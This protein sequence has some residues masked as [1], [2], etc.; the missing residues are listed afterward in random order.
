MSGNR[1]D[2][3]GPTIASSSLAAGRLP[4][5]DHPPRL[6]SSDL[7]R[8]LP[9]HRRSQERQISN[10][11]LLGALTTYGHQS[12]TSNSLAAPRNHRGPKRM[13]PL[14]TL[15]SLPLLAYPGV[16]APVF[17]LQHLNPRSSH[18]PQTRLRCRI[19]SED[20]RRAASAHQ[21]ACSRDR[22]GTSP[23]ETSHA[24]RRRST[25]PT[26]HSS[27]KVERPPFGQCE[28]GDKQRHRKTNTANPAR[29]ENLPPVPR[30]RDAPLGRSSPRSMQML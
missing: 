16:F 23:A 8:R 18:T 17:G 24:A 25:R 13:A 26:F 12:S 19:P 9:C 1:K 4:S 22:V 6:R 15:H 30:P 3:R 7:G 2:H 14:R 11:L 10:A 29:C 20:R 5:G 27:Q 21:H 28:C